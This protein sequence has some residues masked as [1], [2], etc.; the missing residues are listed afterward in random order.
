MSKFQLQFVFTIRTMEHS[1]AKL[2]KIE[3]FKA[4]KKSFA[5][6]GFSP[7]LAAQS[8]P[9]NGRILFGVLL[10]GLLITITI[11]HIFNYAGTFFE[12]TQSIYSASAELLV[13]FALTILILQVQKLYEC[14]DCFD[15]ML[16]MCR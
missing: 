11:V 14:I 2:P 12:Y 13:F 4:V 6:L 7:K 8:H 15:S 10:L 3:A 5:M 16:N 9:L 1:Q